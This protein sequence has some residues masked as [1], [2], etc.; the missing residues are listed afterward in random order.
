M[1][2]ATEND[3]NTSNTQKVAYSVFIVEKA[4]EI[5]FIIYLSFKYY[6]LNTKILLI[7]NFLISEL[8]ITI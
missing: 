5:L 4:L 8:N 2:H 6:K 1:K 3:T 7:N